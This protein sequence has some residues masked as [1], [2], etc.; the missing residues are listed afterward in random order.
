MTKFHGMKTC[1]TNLEQYLPETYH[2]ITH[3]K[4][5]ENLHEIH[6]IQIPT[7][8]KYVSLCFDTREIPLKFVNTDHLQLP[9]IYITFKPDYYHKIC[10][11]IE[12]IPIELPDKKVKTFLSTYATPI[13]KTNYPGTKH[14]NKYFTAGTRVHQ[15]IELNQHTS[16]QIYHFGR[17]LRICY[18]KQ[19]KDN[20]NNTNTNS[21]QNSDHIP[22][23]TNKFTPT[24]PSNK[25][26]PT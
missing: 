14:Y 1:T 15:C 24:T 5:A 6:T 26:N 16:R 19:P 23:P 7:C 9:D 17:H 18:D 20:P 2:K 21:N 11:S 12:Y 4:I 10:I 25:K 3:T 8:H 22:V 13:G